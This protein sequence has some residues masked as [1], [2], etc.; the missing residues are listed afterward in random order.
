MNHAE[1]IPIA[2]AIVGVLLTLA[3]C[4]HT[5]S[6]PEQDRTYAAWE[7]C[8]AEGRG[9]NVELKW[10]EPDGRPQFWMNQAGTAGWQEAQK[11][12]TEQVAKVPLSPSVSISAASPSAASQGLVVPE[13]PVWM[14]GDEW[15]FSFE[16]TTGRG[17]FTW[18]VDREEML[19]GVAYYIIKSGTREIFYR[20][21][22]LASAR[23]TVNGVL[24]TQNMP[25]RLHFV[26]PLA[27]G[28]TWEQTYRF[29]RP[30]DG[31]AYDTRQVGSVDSE[32]TITVPAG[33]F[34]TLKI[35][36]RTR[37]TDTVR[38]EQWYAPEA[39]MWIRTRE[40]REEGLYSRELIGVTR[41]Q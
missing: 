40:Q 18:R 6:T 21:S 31:L 32:E 27:V 39:R 30:V 38:W 8:R 16:S 15:R 22:D 20:K 36:Y 1:R 4:A 10:V 12:F 14:K 9:R 23:E 2:P 35:V 25:P 19:D 17:T 3:A 33:T 28:T 41:A 24:V 11:C 29:E 5:S 26:W 37:R 7:R 34:R 13:P